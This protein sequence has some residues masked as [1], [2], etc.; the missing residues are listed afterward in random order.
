MV[1]NKWILVA[2]GAV[3]AGVVASW[4]LF[5]R[6][7]ANSGSPAG[8]QEGSPEDLPATTSA[9][10]AS[11][12]HFADKLFTTLDRNGDGEVNIREFIISLRKDKDAA[13]AL[14]LGMTVRQEDGSRDKVEELFQEVDADG[15]RTISRTELRDWAIAMRKVSAK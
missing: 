9:Q 10:I 2:G 14:G 11:A 7:R 5:G 6:D 13:M 3:A 15:S 4:H 12:E 8:S 1:A